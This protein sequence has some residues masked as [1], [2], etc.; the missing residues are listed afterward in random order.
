MPPVAV[1]ALVVQPG[2]EFDHRKVIDYDRAKA[3]VSGFT[4]A[5]TTVHGGALSNLV[6]VGLNSSGHD[7]Y[8]ATFTP[9]VA[10]TRGLVDQVVEPAQLLDCALA[11]VETLAALPPATFAL[12]KQQLRQSVTDAMERHGARVAAASEE[13]WTS[14]VT[15]DRVR[16]YVAKTLK[17]A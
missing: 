14:A 8:T 2:V 9:D 6:H 16:A 17:K 1:I 3:V 11:A 10:L 4:L 7:V 5:G 12:T 13:I 15:L